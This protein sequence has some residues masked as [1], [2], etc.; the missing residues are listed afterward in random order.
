MPAGGADHIRMSAG[1]P[2]RQPSRRADE[3]G[4]PVGER[5]WPCLFSPWA[6][7]WRIF[8]QPFVLKAPFVRMRAVSMP[9]PQSIVPLP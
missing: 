1:A 4:L 2:G 6:Q 5:H 3:T 8:S 9:G 7:K